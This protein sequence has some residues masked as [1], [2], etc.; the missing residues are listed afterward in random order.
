MQRLKNKV[1]LIT[2]SA[3]GIGK[4]ISELFA[5]EGA[6]VIVSDINIIA[7]VIKTVSM[8]LTHQIVED[9]HLNISLED[10]WIILN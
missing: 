10:D 2:G 1:A 8:R 9:K 7:W 6:N 3:R 4:A 5:S